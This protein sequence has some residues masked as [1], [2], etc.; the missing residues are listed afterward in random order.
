MRFGEARTTM[1]AIAHTSAHEFFGSSFATR[2]ITQLDDVEFALNETRM[3][4]VRRGGRWTAF[5]KAFHQD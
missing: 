5:A 3:G 2:M 1:Q 4:S